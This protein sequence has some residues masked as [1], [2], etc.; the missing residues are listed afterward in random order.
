MLLL[1]VP[2]V[3]VLLCVCVFLS[4]RACVDV[5]LV[6]QVVYLLVVCI[7]VY[8]EDLWRSVAMCP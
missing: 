1:N 5:E 8:V 2:D 6:A 3:V 4:E 7:Y